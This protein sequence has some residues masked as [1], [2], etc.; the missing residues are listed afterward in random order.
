MERKTLNIN[1]L[2][3]LQYDDDFTK[4]DTI[5]AMSKS[6]NV[7]TDFNNIHD[8]HVEKATEQPYIN[9]D[10]GHGVKPSLIEEEKKIG[11]INNFRGDENQLF[12]R[13][14]LTVPYSGN[15]TYDV[16]KHN[17]LRSYDTASEDRASNSLSGVYIDHQYTPL[18]PNLKDNI[19]N[20]DNIIPEDS[21][22]DW[23]RGG[24]D[25]TQIRKDIDFFERC[26]DDENIRNV[27]VEK[28]TYL[29]NKPVIRTEN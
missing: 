1:T 3:S 19:Q 20:P 24:I 29:T 4:Y 28:K 23:F 6:Q 5:Q 12:P 26:L 16:D 2:T 7:L 21:V 18:V 10:D 27:L 9:F 25:T 8:S 11:K 13:P 15:G 22:P 17:E 14:Y